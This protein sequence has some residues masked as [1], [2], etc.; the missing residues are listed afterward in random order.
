MLCRSHTHMHS[1]PKY[2]PGQSCQMWGFDCQK[3]GECEM[4]LA[5]T[6]GRSGQPVTLEGVFW[7]AGESLGS[8]VW[9]LP[10]LPALPS[11]CLSISCRASG[12]SS[13]AA[14]WL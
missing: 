12:L 8:D 5:R 10:V 7:A 13:R 6:G 9:L 1:G 3:A 11:L 2:M 14:P 4:P